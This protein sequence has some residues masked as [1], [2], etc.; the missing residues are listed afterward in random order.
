MPEKKSSEFW[1][2][3]RLIIPDDAVSDWDKTL[4]EG[5]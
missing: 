2:R 5:G 1:K 4:A 3:K